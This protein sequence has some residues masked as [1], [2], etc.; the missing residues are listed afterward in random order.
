MRYSRK[1][2]QTKDPL[3]FGFKNYTWAIDSVFILNGM[4]YIFARTEGDLCT[5][6]YL[7]LNRPALSYKLLKQGV[8][9]SFSESSKLCSQK[10][11]AVLHGTILSV[12][13]FHTCRGF[14]KG[15]LLVQH[16]LR[17]SWKTCLNTSVMKMAPYRFIICFLWTI[18]C[19]FFN[20]TP[21]YEKHVN[22]LEK[23]CR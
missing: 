11:D 15:A 7:T 5:H 3:P 18:L 21:A 2:L 8:Q 14:C 1:V 6:A 19:Y 12:I 9:G 22:G 17:D 10:P 4:I 13:Y 20:R 23:S 16:Y